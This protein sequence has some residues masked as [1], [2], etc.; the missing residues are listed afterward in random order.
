MPTSGTRLLR[1]VHANIGEVLE[2]W[3]L[4]LGLDPGNRYI[5]HA[6]AKAA[7]L[8]PHRIRQLGLVSFVYAALFLTE[9]IGLWL[10]NSG[11]PGSM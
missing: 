2:H 8:S 7:N 3:V 9:G 6:L 4:R 11:W 10:E 1:L 5:E